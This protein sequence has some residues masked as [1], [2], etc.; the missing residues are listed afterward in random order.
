MRSHTGHVASCNNVCAPYALNLV[1]TCVTDVSP[2]GCCLSLHALILSDTKVSDVSALASCQS[3]HTVN[4]WYAPVSD[5]SPLTICQSLHTLIL[6]ETQVSDVSGLLCVSHFTHSTSTKL[7]S[8]TSRYW[9]VFHR[10]TLSAST[11][12][13]PAMCLLSRCVSHYTH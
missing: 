13:K 12:L 3:L 9:G 4:L 7:T 8:A 6:S 5:V 1:G 11:G 2:L 10:C